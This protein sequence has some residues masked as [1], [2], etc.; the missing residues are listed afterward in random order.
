MKPEEHMFI[1]ILVNTIVTWHS[2][3][4]GIKIAKILE[5]WKSLSKENDIRYWSEMIDCVKKSYG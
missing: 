5:E 2:A 4:F 3:K 1:V